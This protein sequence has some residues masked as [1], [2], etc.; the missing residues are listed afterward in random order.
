MRYRVFERPDGSLAIWR[1]LTPMLDGEDGA[2]YLEREAHR[3]ARD[4]SLA[5]LPF[6]DVDEA[7]LPTT[8]AARNRWRLRGGRVVVDVAQPAQPSR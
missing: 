4:P 2:A 8:R 7:D 3:A 6:T 1:P 5:G